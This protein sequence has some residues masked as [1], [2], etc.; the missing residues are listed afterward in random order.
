[1]TNSAKAS[2]SSVAVEMLSVTIKL[3]SSTE[4]EA[5]ELKPEIDRMARIATQDTEDQMFDYENEVCAAL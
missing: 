3:D 5:V 1:M 2:V 4:A